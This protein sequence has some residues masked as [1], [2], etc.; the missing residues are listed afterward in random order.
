MNSI[1]LITKILYLKLIAKIFLYALTVVAFSVLIFSIIKAFWLL[2][3]L[4]F[5]PCF[6][7]AF[8][9]YKI[10]YKTIDEKPNQISTGDLN[11]P[12]KITES[13]KD[14]E[15]ELN[16]MSENDKNITGET[17]KNGNL[18]SPNLNYK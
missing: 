15:N 12:S 6:C 18:F 4:S 7:F 16:P 1:E 14:N 13:N 3:I 11:Y 8:I 10:K 5:I 2:A 9:A 17:D